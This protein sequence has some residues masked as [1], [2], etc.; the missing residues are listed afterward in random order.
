MTHLPPLPANEDLRLQ[1]LEKYKILDSEP[2][3]AFDRLTRLAKDICQAPIALVSLVDRDRQ[4]FKAKLGLD[5]QETPRDVAFCAH[6]ILKDEVLVVPD[7]TLDERFNENPLVIGPPH[8]RSY[9]GAPLITKEGLRLG[10]LCVIHDQVTRLTALQVS[11]LAHLAAIAVDELELRHTLGQVATLQEDLE[12]QTAGLLIANAALDDQ[13][14]QLAALVEDRELL[15]QRVEGSRR[16]IEKFVETVPIPIYSRDQDHRVTHANPAYAAFLGLDCKDV[17]GKHIDEL[18]DHQVASEILGHDDELL[19]S[20]S[21]QHRYE[22][23][24]Y[25]GSQDSYRDIVVHKALIRASDGTAQGLVGAIVDVTEQNALREKLERLASTDPLTGAVNRRAFLDRA[26]GELRRHRR[27]DRPL[28]LILIDI[29][30]FK[31]INDTYG[32][33]AGDQLLCLLCRVC[34]NNLRTSVD[35]LA[36]LGGEEFAVLAPETDAQ[37]AAILAERLRREIARQKLDYDGQEIGF[38][39]SFGV[40]S[41]PGRDTS[42]TIADA[43]RQADNCLYASKRSGRNRVTAFGAPTEE[44]PVDM[45]SPR[46]EAA[47]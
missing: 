35:V 24:V 28:S 15:C 1:T 2:E 27:Y 39:A 21:G 42:M 22:R 19:A 46:Q 44:S 41:L 20:P 31:R 16:L 30:Y 40:I 29:D 8:I 34:E 17:L 25:R 36:R 5:T 23:R 14:R 4:W 45:D 11:Q 10:T 13:A 26:D 9:A 33:E 32:H 6:A 43:L 47:G 12:Y 37:G 38:T 7:T 18:Y 3:E